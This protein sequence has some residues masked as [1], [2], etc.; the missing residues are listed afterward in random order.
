MVDGCIG[1]FICRD[2][3]FVFLNNRF[4]FFVFIIGFIWVVWEVLSKNK[5]IDFVI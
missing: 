2:W 1:L 3:K 5:G 4:L